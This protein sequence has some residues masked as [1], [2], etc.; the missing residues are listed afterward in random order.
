MGVSPEE[1]VCSLVWPDLRCRQGFA[2]GLWVMQV[3]HGK[4]HKSYVGSVL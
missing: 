2:Q 4:E 1:G 3:C